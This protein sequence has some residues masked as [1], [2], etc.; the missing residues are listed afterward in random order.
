MDA[1]AAIEEHRTSTGL[2]NVKI[3]MWAFLASDCLLFGALISTFLL[4]H[5][6]TGTGP[7]PAE[8][9]DIPFT[10]VS[11]F[12]LLMSSLTMVLALA[13]MQR[14]EEHRARAWL[15]ATALLGLTF[16]SGQ[17]YEFTTFV[18]EGAALTTSP[19]TSSFFLMTGFHGAHVAGGVLLLLT[20]TGMSLDGRLPSHRS[21]T[22]E[23]AGLYWHFVDVVWIVIFAVAYLIPTA[24]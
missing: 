19:F 1:P 15:V 5:T 12:V 11:S 9:Y 23:M 7:T 13:A 20:L 24:K 6:Q 17:V 10:S 2:S 21:E 8:L 22:V 4:Y 14:G 18:H 16:L 3:A